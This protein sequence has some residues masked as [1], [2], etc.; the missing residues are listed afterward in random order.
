M[1]MPGPLFARRF[2]ALDEHNPI[3]GIDIF[4]RKSYGLGSSLNLCR[5][6]NWQ[7]IDV[8]KMLIGYDENMTDIVR[9]LSY[10]DEGSDL[11]ILVNKIRSLDRVVLVLNTLH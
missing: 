8:L 3:T 9:P 7:I 5:N 11:V 6:R 2:I 10:A 4:H 1:I